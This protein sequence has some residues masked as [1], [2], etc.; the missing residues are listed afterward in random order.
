MAARDTGNACRGLVRAR[1][2]P[3]DQPLRLPKRGVPEIVR[4]GLN[5]FQAALGAIDPELQPIFVA[6]GHLA[7]PDRAFG[8]PAVAFGKAQHDMSVV[9]ELPARHKAVQISGNTFGVKPRHEG[10]ELIGMSAD[11][12]RRAA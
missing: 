3:G 5:P 11:V 9:I 8:A 10:D 7:Y 2:T 12:A 1:A 6:R 4:I